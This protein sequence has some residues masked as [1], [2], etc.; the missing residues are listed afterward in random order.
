MVSQD[1]AVLRL[2]YEATGGADWEHNEG[3]GEPI[4]CDA[5]GVESFDRLRLARLQLDSTFTSTCLARNG[6]VKGIVGQPQVAQMV[7]MGE[8]A[9]E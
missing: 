1:A 6:R 5:Y 8:Y 3:W 9:I 7:C 2:L 4:G